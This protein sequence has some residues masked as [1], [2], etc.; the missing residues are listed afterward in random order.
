MRKIWLMTALMVVV[1]GTVHG[2]TMRLKLASSTYYPAYSKY[3]YEDPILGIY[4][5]AELYNLWRVFGIGASWHSTYQSYDNRIHQMQSSKYYLHHI[6]TISGKNGLYQAWGLL[7]GVRQ[8]SYD[9][10]HYKTDEETQTTFTRPLIGMH[11]STQGF[12]ATLSWSQRQNHHSHFE[13]EM[14]YRMENGWYVMVGKSLKGP[15]IGMQSDMWIYAGY[16]LSF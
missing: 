8:T 11:M 1:S 15:L 12:G 13:L 7:A 2:L 16:E 6:R 5:Q 10:Q 3:D 14:K 9:Y 4:G